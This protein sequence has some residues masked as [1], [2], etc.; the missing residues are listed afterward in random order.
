MVDDA[1]RSAAAGLL[2]QLTATP[3]D[4]VIHGDLGPEHVL[5]V[6]DALSGVIDFTDARLGDAALDLA[7]VRHGTTPAFVHAF[8]AAYRPTRE[9]RTR[10]LLWHRLGPW[11][12]VEHG[13]EVND[14]A[15]VRS[16]LDGLVQRLTPAE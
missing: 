4:T 1:H 15:E 10:A 7:W 8:D 14:R 11:H 13:L 12:A 6:A 2:D 16:G 9:Q 3:A 5:A